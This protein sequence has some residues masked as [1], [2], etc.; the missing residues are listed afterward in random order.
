M[1]DKEDVLC[2][3]EAEQVAWSLAAFVFY[4]SVALAIP[5]LRLGAVGLAVVFLVFALRKIGPMK[6]RSAFV[7]RMLGKDKRTY[8]YEEFRRLMA[9]RLFQGEFWIGDGFLWEQSQCLKA[10][11]LGRCDMNRVYRKAVT[12]EAL[13]HFILHPGQWLHPLKNGLE[14]LKIQRRVADSN[15]FPWIH[16]IEPSEHVMVPEDD[17]FKHVLVVGS[18]G[19]GKT[20]FLQSVIA[21]AIQKEWEVLVVD[22]K[23]DDGLMNVIGTFS[24]LCGREFKFFSVSNTEEST[25]INLMANFGRGGELAPRLASVLQGGGDSEA[26]RKM[27]E[28]AARAVI[29]GMLLLEE[30]PTCKLI[31]DRLM[32]RVSFANRVLTRWLTMKLEI[33]E[34]DLPKGRTVETTFEVL[35]AFYRAK[36]VLSSDVTAVVDLA[37]KSDEILDK[38]ISGLKDL[39]AQLTRDD[40]E[41][42]LS[43]SAENTTA[44]TDTGK[45]IARNAIFYLRTDALKDSSL[46]HTLGTLFL[47]DLASVAG[48]I[49]NRK[50]TN[51]KKVLIVVDEA[52][53]VCCDAM[54]ALLSKARGAGMGLIL[55]TQSIADFTARLGSEAQTNRVLANVMTRF[56]MRLQ[57]GD[58]RDFFAEKGPVASIFTKSRSHAVSATSDSVLPQGMN[59]GERETELPFIPLITPHLLSSLPNGESFAMTSAGYVTKLYMP[60]IVREKRR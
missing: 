5:V 44:F 27:S 39:L 51:N 53:E 29:G 14:I 60:Q 10:H 50:L 55:A 42:L 21:Q 2:N 25:P 41:H 47:T 11:E 32:D 9:G 43:P 38:T 12:G 20:C 26:F 23:G 3:L 48:D 35:E 36:G 31:Y 49:Y 33:Q 30:K 54:I 6:R 8:T 34:D 37:H 18:S 22:P 28:S 17:I 7:H 59:H 57:D 45:L 19:S 24:E 46:A 4:V 58:S 40:F 52:S 13:K 15:G 1:P 56:V 16:A